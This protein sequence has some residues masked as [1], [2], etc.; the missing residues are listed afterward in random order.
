EIDGITERIKTRLQWGLVIDIQRPDLETRIAILKRKA[1]ELDLYLTD[2]IFAL[3]ASSVK[4]SIRELEGALIKLLAHADVMKVEIDAEMVRDI[5][6]IQEDSDINKVTME[7]VSRATANYFKI[8]LSDLK[9]QARNKDIALAR[10]AG[11]YLSQKLLKATLKEIGKFYGGRDHTTVISGIEKAK[12][13]MHTNIQFSR[14][15]INIENN[16]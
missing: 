13:L 16:L 15:V 12:Q 9:S 11:M 1:N 2:D 14:D 3:I 7:T 4:T 5:F 6:N 10:H 8:P